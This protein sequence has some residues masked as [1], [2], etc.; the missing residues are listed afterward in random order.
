MK[1]EKMMKNM[2]FLLNE[3]HKEWERSGA[4]VSSELIQA[5]NAKQLIDDIQFH[6]AMK[7]KMLDESDLIFRKIVTETKETY[8]CLRIARKIT[9][10]YNKTVDDKSKI[11]FCILLD[12]EEK[13]IFKMLKAS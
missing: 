1:A 7:Q 6:V 5:D 3:L 13:K 11:D 10:E 9:E 12:K 2:E 4:P 8:I